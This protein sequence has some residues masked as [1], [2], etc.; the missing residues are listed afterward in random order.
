MSRSSSPRDQ[1]GG[2]HPGRRRSRNDT[3]LPAEGHLFNLVEPEEVEPPWKRWSSAL[4]RPNGL[5]SYASKERITDRAVAEAVAAE[6]AR[7]TAP[8]PV[9]VEER[10]Q[11][12]QKLCA[13]RFGWSAAQTLSEYATS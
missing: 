4:L 2:G 5:Y 6:A 3:I 1:Q 10:R 13:S 8:L 12:I 9:K 7:A 11:S